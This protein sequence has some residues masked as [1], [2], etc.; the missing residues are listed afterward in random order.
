VN[1]NELRAKQ[2]EIFPAK[3]ECVHRGKHLL[4][5]RRNEPG[6]RGRI[7]IGR[8]TI[9]RQPLGAQARGQVSDIRLRVAELR[10][11]H[12]IDDPDIL[13]IAQMR[14]GGFRQHQLTVFVGLHVPL[15]ALVN[16]VARG[17]EA[18]GSPQVVVAADREHEPNALPDAVVEGREQGGPRRIA[19]RPDSDLRLRGQF[20]ALA[21]VLEGSHHFRNVLDVNAKV[22]V[23]AQLGDQHRKAQA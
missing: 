4:G 19:D 18:N 20:R 17:E 6:R 11:N 1:Q 9:D 2:A 12:G 16:E 15:D 21:E 10:L 7:A 3:R 23:P 14:C 13:R 5:K 8:Q 22:A